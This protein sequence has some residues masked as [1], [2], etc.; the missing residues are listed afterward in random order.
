MKKTITTL[1]M[2]ISLL[3]FKQALAQTD[4][5]SFQLIFD[6]AYRTIEYENDVNISASIPFNITGKLKSDITYTFTIDSNLTTI[7][8]KK[9]KFKLI[10]N[11]FPRKLKTNDTTSQK[12]EF[13][14]S[15][16]DINPDLRNC[17]LT[18]KLKD[19]TINDSNN[20][21]FNLTNITIQFKPSAPNKAFLS[22]YGIV[23]GGNFTFKDGISPDNFYYQ[24]YINKYKAFENI[25]S[26]FLRK[27]GFLAGMYQ[28]RNFIDGTPKLFDNDIFKDANERFISSTRIS[29]PLINSGDSGR[30]IHE[31]LERKITLTTK[32]TGIYFDV[33]YYLLG[34]KNNKLYGTINF[35]YINR[36]IIF[37]YTYNTLKRDTTTRISITPEE[38][39]NNKYTLENPTSKVISTHEHYFA[40][41]L[42]YRFTDKS[43]AFDIGGNFGYTGI[44]YNNT[45]DIYPF[46]NLHASFSNLEYGFKIGFDT[47]SAFSNGTSPYWTVYVGKAFSINKIAELLKID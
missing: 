12:L 24:I 31:V 29:E 19:S 23:T 36:N 25:N 45:N 41:G 42:Y 47:R 32:S 5:N 13:I 44:I 20:F 40:L 22:S 34:A 33:L 8:F 7:D 2:V 35:N 46:Y 1:I 27:F 39:I 43:Y 30:L 18:F 10:S 9:I 28:N 14:I 3:N 37:D 26:K 21:D 15:G 17:L 38:I 11:K 4:T 6:S 16:L